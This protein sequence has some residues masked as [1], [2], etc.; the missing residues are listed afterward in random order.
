[1]RPWAWRP[2]SALEATPSA[3]ENV[4][5]RSKAKFAA[6]VLVELQFD[7]AAAGVGAVDVAQVLGAGGVVGDFDGRHQPV[8]VLVEE[9]EL[10]G[11]HVGELVL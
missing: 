10:P 4:Y 6:E 3:Y 11:Q 7:A 2:K 8:V 5:A 1:V 9:R